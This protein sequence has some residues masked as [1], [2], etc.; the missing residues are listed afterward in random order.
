ASGGMRVLDPLYL[1]DLRRMQ[2]VGLD[3]SVLAL[4]VMVS[5]LSGLVFG[6]APVWLVSRLRL[7]DSL[8]DT[9]QQHSEG[10]VQRFFHDGLVVAQMSLAVV[11]L[12]GAGLMI[13]STV[14][15]L[16]VNPGLDP[17]GLFGAFFPALP[18]SN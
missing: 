4:T 14:R 12:V 3:G 9:S 13:Q 16:R 6:V 2:E 18:F 5:A 10:F 7:K 8:K 11:L 15:R 1:I 17:V